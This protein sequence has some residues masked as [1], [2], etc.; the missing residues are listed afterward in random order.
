MEDDGAGGGSAAAQGS[1]ERADAR[2]HR[3]DA[4]ER[5]GEHSLVEVGPVRAP[6]SARRNTTSR[7]IRVTG[8]CHDSSS[9]S[10]TRARLISA[11]AARAAT[12]GRASAAHASRCSS[13]LPR[14]SYSREDARDVAAA[15]PSRLAP[16]TFASD[17]D[18]VRSTARRFAGRPR[19]GRARRGGA[20]ADPRRLASTPATLA[21][22]PTASSSPSDDASL[23]EED[24]FVARRRRAEEALMSAIEFDAAWLTD[25]TVRGRITGEGAVAPPPKT[26]RRRPGYTPTASDLARE[27]AARDAA[28]SAAHTSA[29]LYDDQEFRR[30]KA[31]SL[32]AI[33]Q[34][35]CTPRDVP[36]R[37]AATAEASRVSSPPHPPLSRTSTR[38][39]RLARSF[40]SASVSVTTPT[41]SRRCRRI[42]RRSSRPSP[43]ATIR[44][45]R[46]NVAAPRD[47]KR[48]RA[49]CEPSPRARGRAYSIPI[50]PRRRHRS[51]MDA[52]MA[53]G[54]VGGTLKGTSDR[55]GDL[56]V[57]FWNLWGGSSECRR[58]VTESPRG[59]VYRDPAHGSRRRS[60]RSVRALRGR[61]HA[62]AP[63]AEI[64]RVG[65]RDARPTDRSD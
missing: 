33:L 36:A 5:V 14:A 63:R 55:A 44:T 40:A 54:G 31:A 53:N 48:R 11:R 43:N 39:A 65:R 9:V 50:A 15:S 58:V 23:A 10:H 3:R 2:W 45:R 62:P 41:S 21:T 30:A 35:A 46:W 19:P 60:T 42:P 28:A 29:T 49:R 59:S 47:A 26:P 8:W 20:R 18:C 6:H 32:Y 16:G 37:E 57:R 22:T 4:S 56:T 12:S 7:E 17:P 34:P 27:A 38:D 24:P 52:R 61:A 25:A 64:A 1:M 51:R 13:P